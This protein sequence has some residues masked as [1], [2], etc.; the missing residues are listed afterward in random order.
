MILIN[1][2]FL[3]NLRF[4]VDLDLNLMIELYFKEGCY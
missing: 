3:G 2:W 4:Q 1:L